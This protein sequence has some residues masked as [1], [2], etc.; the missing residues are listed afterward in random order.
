M[1]QATTIGLILALPRQIYPQEACPSCGNH[2]PP[3]GRFCSNCG[4]RL[5]CQACGTVSLGKNFC[6]NCGQN[7]R[8]LE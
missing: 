8:R 2:Q 7:L 1:G 4:I 5:R 6:H 3:G